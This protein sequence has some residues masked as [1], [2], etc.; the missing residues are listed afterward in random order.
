VDFF[1]KEA[2]THRGPAIF[3]LK[4]GAPLI[5]SSCIRIKGP[6]YRIRFEKIEL[7][8]PEASLEDKTIYIMAE[9]TKILEAKIKE[10]PEQ[11]FWMHKRWKTQRRV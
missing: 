2:S 11:Y 9:L 6:Y 1:G 3:H 7:S 4:T 8:P 10:H 5:M